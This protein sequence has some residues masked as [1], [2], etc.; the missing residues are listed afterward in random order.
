MET[1][2]IMAP[3]PRR[4]QDSFLEILAALAGV[5]YSYDKYH[6]FEIEIGHSCGK[7]A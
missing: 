2:G 7:A 5:N 3:M 4:C 1:A 6:V